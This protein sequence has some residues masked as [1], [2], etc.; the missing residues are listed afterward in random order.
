M[1]FG[2]VALC[3]R[4][5]SLCG[6]RAIRLRR[7]VGLRIRFPCE[8]VSH[9]LDASLCLAAFL[10]VWFL[11]LFGCVALLGCVFNSVVFAPSG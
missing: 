5:L 1:L 6:L 3:G 4:D 7:P 2:C 9:R 11:A 8:F 10:T